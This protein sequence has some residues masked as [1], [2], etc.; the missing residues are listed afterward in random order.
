[1]SARPMCHPP[2]P[3]LQN[4]LIFKLGRAVS[5]HHGSHGLDDWFVG[6]SAKR[7]MSY[8]SDRLAASPSTARHRAGSCSCRDKSHGSRD[9]P[10]SAD[11]IFRYIEEEVV[12]TWRRPW[13]RGPV[14]TEK[15]VGC[16]G[17]GRSPCRRR[18]GGRRHLGGDQPRAVFRRAA[19]RQRPWS[20]NDGVAASNMPRWLGKYKLYS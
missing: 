13:R 19:P 3:R 16:A 5:G 18:C 7:V 17:R 2:D 4:T 1:M 12:R 20:R 6:P 15:G 11:Q 14:K 9:N 8:P 10:F